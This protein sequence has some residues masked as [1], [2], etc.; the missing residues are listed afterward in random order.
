[1]YRIFVWLLLVVLVCG[2]YS[3]KKETTVPNTTVVAP[4]YLV[5]RW[6]VNRINYKIY[7]LNGAHVRDTLAYDNGND[8]SD[9]AGEYEVFLKNGQ[10]YHISQGTISG[11]DGPVFKRDTDYSWT[12]IL[13]KDSLK[14]ADLTYHYSLADFAIIQLNNTG[15]QQETTYSNAPLSIFGI[16][17]PD[18]YAQ[19]KVV[20][21]SFWIKQP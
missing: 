12:Y 3:C 7:A 19:Y 8:L 6:K 4:A 16:S 1:M 21:D 14:L 10:G 5:G 13:T 15:M 18:P 9:S 17:S 11:T 20:A 2:M